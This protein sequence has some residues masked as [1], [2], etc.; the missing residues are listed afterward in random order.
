MSRH[1]HVARAAITRPPTLEQR[2][3]R[4]DGDGDD[5]LGAHDSRHRSG[6]DRE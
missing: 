6:G 3:I 5:G 4:T 2:F 1:E